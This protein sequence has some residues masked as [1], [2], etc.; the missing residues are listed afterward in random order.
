MGLLLSSENKNLRKNSLLTN[1]TSRSVLKTSM[2]LDYHNSLFRLATLS[3]QLQYTLNH[4][5]GRALLMGFLES[6]QSVDNLKF[7][8]EIVSFRRLF[9]P[10]KPIIFI[11]IKTKASYIL[12]NYVMDDSPFQ[13]YLPSQVKDQYLKLT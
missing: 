11:D 1:T 12:A 9:L 7:Y 6:E 4:P 2:V 13:V 8:E 3:S 10:L 5:T